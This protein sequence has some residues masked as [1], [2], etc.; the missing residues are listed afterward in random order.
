[1]GDVKYSKHIHTNKYND[2]KNRLMLHSIGMSFYDNNIKKIFFADI[3]QEMIIS[4]KKLGL[5]IPL[6]N[7]IKKYYL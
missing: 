4:L 2:I 7:E 6:K 3:P 1:M 5:S